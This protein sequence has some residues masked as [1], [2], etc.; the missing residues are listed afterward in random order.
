MSDADK[1]LELAKALADNRLS[2]ADLGDDSHGPFG[3]LRSIFHAF[4]SVAATDM[5]EDEPY[6]F[7]WHHLQ[8]HE[9]IGQGGFGD[10]Y[11]AFDP[12][13]HRSVALKLSRRSH[14][15]AEAAFIAE[16]RLMAR[17]RH[18]NILAIHGADTDSERAGIW[19]DLLTGETLDIVLKQHAQWTTEE[20]LAIAT[21]LA[22]A[23][24]A[25]HENGLTHGDIKPANVM[26]SSTGIPVL[27]DFGAGRELSKAWSSGAASPLLMAPEQF[28]SLETSRA[29]DVYAFGA[30]LYRVS[31]GR[32]P[33]EAQNFEALEAMHKAGASPD[34]SL[35][36]RRFRS[37]LKRMLRAVP[38]MR[39]DIAQISHDLAALASAPQRRRRRLATVAVIASLAVGLI[40]ASYGTKRAQEAEVDALEQKIA[41]EA[42]LDFMQQLL[43]SP[44]GINQGANVRMIDALDLANTRLQANPPESTFVRAK[45]EQTLGLTYEN[46]DQYEKARPLLESALS[47]YRAGAAECCEDHV[48]TLIAL[49][50]NS[51]SRGDVDLAL[52]RLN[53]ADTAIAAS[54]AGLPLQQVEILAVR[55]NAMSALG[56]EGDT[57]ALQRQAL[58]RIALLDG[59]HDEL[60]ADMQ[61][62]L[63]ASLIRVSDLETA[64]VLSAESLQWFES[65]FG[66]EH[67]KTTK[68]RHTLSIVTL[69]RGDFAEA[70]RLSRI[71][72]SVMERVEPEAS[73][74]RM[75]T[76]ITVLDILNETGRFEEALTLAYEIYDLSVKLHGAQHERSMKSQANIGATLTAMGRYD[77][78][79]DVFRDNWKLQGEIIGEHALD[80]LI[81]R[82]NLAEALLLSGRFGE[83][84]EIAISANAANIEYLGA[85]HYATL[86]FAGILAQAKSRLGKAGEAVV[87]LE[88]NLHAIQTNF[89]EDNRMGWDTAEYL[90]EAL[91]A[92]GQPARAL[93]LAEK[94]VTYRA[95][96]QGESHPKTV[97]A[98]Q[99][100][101]KS[102]SMP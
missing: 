62:E 61:A 17:L 59:D 41:A 102:R 47:L 9:K 70:E 64:E 67:F 94:L 7:L 81:S 65:R 2:D 89:G 51:L 57:V 46:L 32:Y 92:D 53:E 99:L 73:S 69:L 83:A 88:E 10:V 12:I 30:L 43:M 76:L 18:P 6:D 3:T 35:P 90:I 100:L 11:R 37:L 55:A 19:C 85:D 72:L 5:V 98:R 29:S 25:I 1:S 42:S 13:L 87:L 84:E 14:S 80:T 63:A 49:A 39:P 82:G 58:D 79:A 22:S 77:D 44:T 78:A 20:V 97:L 31:S 96:S 101:Q 56:Q 66:I 33:I 27:M 95:T 50:E 91:L 26:I 38:E 86:Y 68:P 24:E 8:V 34:W 71:N 15:A 74:D 52:T 54:S 16:A 21:P 60:R 75:A 23:I 40:M 93:P 28:E 4:R 48:I 36:Q 45:V